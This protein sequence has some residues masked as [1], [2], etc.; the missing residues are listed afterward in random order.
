MQTL[1]AIILVIAVIATAVA[2]VRGLIAFLKTTE[3]DLNAPGDG[4]TPSQ[5]KQNKMM[6]QRVLFQGAA[7]MIVILLLAM[8]R[9]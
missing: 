6:T 3:A 7:I 2:L 8:S 1:L 9:G 5:L 4:P